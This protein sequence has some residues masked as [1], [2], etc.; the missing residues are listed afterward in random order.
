[1]PP[2]P[3]KKAEKPRTTPLKA[4]YALLFGLEITQRD[5]KGQA[6]TCACLFCKHVGRET[7]GGA[8]KRART[9]SVHYFKLPFVKSNIND[10]MKAQHPTHFATYSALDNEKRKVYFSGQRPIMQ[11]LDTVQ[12]AMR[13][14]I[15]AR[16]VED[17][18]GD[19]FFD[20]QDGADDD[21]DALITRENALKLFAL[22]DDGSYMATIK[23]PARYRL[24]MQHTLVGLSFRQTAAVIGHHKDEFGSAKLVGLNDHIVGQMVRVLVSANLQVLSMVMCSTVC[25][26]FSLAGD[27]SSHLGQSF[28]DIRVRIC[29]SGVLYNFHLVVIPF[30]DRHTAVNIAGMVMKLLEI[31][32]PPWRSSR[33]PPTAKTR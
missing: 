10:H 14:P 20:P 12:D 27:G 24:A 15:S 25:F 29:V 13:F 23:N 9:E 26:G 1:M 7:P 22:Q 6:M 5:E 28:F 33:S 32:C 18:I 11:Y 2:K 19:L 3:R 8:R 30:F 17:L 4:E 16:I 31:L 21:D